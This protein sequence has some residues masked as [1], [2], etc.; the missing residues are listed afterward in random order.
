MHHDPR[1]CREPRLRLE[2]GIIRVHCRRLVCRISVIVIVRDRCHYYAGTR[3][4]LIERQ[5]SRT[6]E[7]Q[8]HFNAAVSDA[9]AVALHLDMFPRDRSR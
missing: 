5:F 2:V 6:I 8:T 4:A 1:R 9:V 3:I 7:P